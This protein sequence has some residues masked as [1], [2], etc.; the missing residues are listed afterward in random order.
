VKRRRTPRGDSYLDPRVP[1]P[2]DGGNERLMPPFLLAALRLLV[3]LP[4]MAVPGWLLSRLMPSRHPAVTTLLGSAA[5]LTLSVIT[6]DA[7][8][9]PV[10]V[11]SLL[12]AELGACALVYALTRGRSL[13]GCTAQAPLARPRGIDLLWFLPV[14]AAGCSI[15]ARTVVD[16]LSGYD[17]GF[18]WDHIARLLLSHH[19]LA[20]YPPSPPRTSASTPGATG[21][22][23]SPRSSTSRSMRVLVPT[24]P[25]SWRFGPWGSSAS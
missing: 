1:R 22:L 3:V 18:R 4:L 16:P 24:V 6:I 25:N 7:L 11:A 20:M 17:N 12:L 15:A 2:K 23:R 8:G 10:T 19:S 21:S 9:I 14:A 5:A 13:P